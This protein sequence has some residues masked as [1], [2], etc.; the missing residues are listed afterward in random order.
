MMMLPQPPVTALG[1]QGP[2]GMAG[3]TGVILLLAGFVVLIK[4]S[5]IAGAKLN[6]NGTGRVMMPVPQLTFREVLCCRCGE[7]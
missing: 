7:R 5:W 3:I 4:P 6:G 2:K 1:A